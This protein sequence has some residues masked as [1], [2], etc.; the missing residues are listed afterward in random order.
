MFYFGLS[1]LSSRQQISFYLFFCWILL[2]LI[3][4]ITR[5]LPSAHQSSQERVQLPSIHDYFIIANKNS[6]SR[7]E[8]RKFTI[9]LNNFGNKWNGVRS[10][11]P[12]KNRLVKLIDN[13][14][15]EYK[16]NV[17]FNYDNY[18]KINNSNLI[19]TH[20][21]ATIINK[22]NYY[23]NPSKPNYYPPQILFYFEPPRLVKNSLNYNYL[24]EKN[25]KRS[26]KY[27][28]KQVDGLLTYN[29]GH[30]F[31][32]SFAVDRLFARDYSERMRLNLF[33]G[34]NSSESSKNNTQQNSNKILMA[35][36]SNCHKNA[37]PY[38]MMILNKLKKLLGPKMTF[39]GKCGTDTENSNYS[40]LIPDKQYSQK[41]HSV[42]EALDP[43]REYKFYAAFENNRCPYY[44]TEKLWVNSLSKN[45]VPILAGSSREIY[46]EFLPKNSFLHVDDFES[47]ELLTEKLQKIAVDDDLYQGFFEWKQD[48]QE[49]LKLKDYLSRENSGICPIIDSFYEREFEDYRLGE[50]DVMRQLTND[51][52]LCEAK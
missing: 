36:V 29:P 15:P 22:S 14:C 34:I 45:V 38:R 2:I 41:H 51:I 4:I 3:N 30:N 18:R 28:L 23:S 17:L 46:Q 31:T 48:E 13:F 1:I 35:I 27:L 16:E 25:G 7:K 20:F 39:L 52:G 32:M 5:H 6:Q 26:R 24:T 12:F 42:T 44:I 10:S 21:Y 8:Q 47:V 9:Y 40:Q 19:L 43:I 37:D 33:D 49:I 50:F 11:V